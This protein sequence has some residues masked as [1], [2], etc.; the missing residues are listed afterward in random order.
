MG[1]YNAQIC[2][3]LIQ[4]KHMK[5]NSETNINL[6]FRYK[7]MNSENE[8]KMLIFSNEELNME[9]DSSSNMKFEK[10]KFSLQAND[11]FETKI[12]G[13]SAR[14]L[15]CAKLLIKGKSN[16]EIAKKLALSATTVSTYKK[17]ILQKTKTKNILEFAKLIQKQ[18]KVLK[19]FNF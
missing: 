7:I 2:I 16:T 4:F 13:L 8:F 3:N 6:N 9:F 14:E 1:F 19:K 18:P 10:S 11:I 12:V 15:E 5:V 17:R